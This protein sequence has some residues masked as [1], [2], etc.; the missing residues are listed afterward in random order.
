MRVIEEFS[1]L[2]PELCLYKFMIEGNFLRLNLVA[3]LRGIGALRI[4]FEKTSI[5][6]ILVH[7][8]WYNHL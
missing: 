3:N 8:N 1:L 4:S 2:M 5:L 6:G 7:E